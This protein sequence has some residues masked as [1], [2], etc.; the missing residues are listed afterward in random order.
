MNMNEID[1]ALVGNV[2]LFRLVL[3]G[4]SMWK[5]YVNNSATPYRFDI[6]MDLTEDEVRQR[7]SR[8]IMSE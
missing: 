3:A 5:G 7:M 2:S 8:R 4:S 1:I 6:D